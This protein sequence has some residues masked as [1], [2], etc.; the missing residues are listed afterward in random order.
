MAPHDPSMVAALRR[1]RAGY[2]ARGL[3][4]RVAQ[5]D[6][7]LAY[8]GAGDE[9]DVP[10]GRTGHDPGQQTAA[11]ASGGIVPGG[12]QSAITDDSSPAQADAEPTAEADDK[13]RRGRP[14]KPR[15]TSGNI[16]RE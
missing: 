5:V 13:P 16:I 4:D 10:E 11:P 1:E 7:Q 9:P 6:E 2:E 8:Y 3:T 12:P 15:D 14:R